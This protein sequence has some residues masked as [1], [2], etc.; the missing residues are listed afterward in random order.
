MSKKIIGIGHAIVDISCQ[1]DDEFLKKNNLVKGSMTLIDNDLFHK[2]SQL[3]ISKISSGGSV[4]NSIATM[5]SLNANCE[6]FG[7]VGD[8]EFGKMFITDLEKTS[9]KFIGVV[10]KNKSSAT[11]FILIT[12]D[13]ERTMCTY[14]GCASNIAEEF[15]AKIDFSSAKFLYLEGYLWDGNTTSNSLKQAISRAKKNNCQIAFSLSD[16]FCVERHRDDFINL[17]KNDLDILFANE[18][19]YLAL[20]HD[21]KFDLKLANDFIKNI[22]S[23]NK[24]LLTIITRSEKGC[25]VFN[26]DFNYLQFPS[27][28]VEKIIDTTGAGDNF[29]SGWLLGFKD[30]NQKS[31]NNNLPQDANSNKLILDKSAYLANFLAGKIIQK[32]GARFDQQEINEI[33]KTINL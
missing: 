12:A 24:N 21:Q 18:I 14:L 6:F 2:L 8:D 31:L 16:A 10:E 11:C 9:T 22:S 5:A 26:N 7:V 20:S 3:K 13:G 29:A 33:K 30:Y 23:E 1:V 25:C 32:I 17:I 4:G 28:K 19:E 27:N 15:I